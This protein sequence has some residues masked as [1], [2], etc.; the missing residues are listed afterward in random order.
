M[1]VIAAGIGLAVIGPQVN[2]A[3]M[4]ARGEQALISF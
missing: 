4:L 3:G 1:L 2:L